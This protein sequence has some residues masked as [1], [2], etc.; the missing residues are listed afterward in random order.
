MQN[1][2]APANMHLRNGSVKDFVELLNDFL[3]DRPLRSLIASNEAV[4]Q[5]VVEILLDPPRTRVPELYLVMNGNKQKGDGRFGFPDM[6]I[7]G[8][9]GSDSAVVLELKDIH[10]SGLWNGRQGHRTKWMNPSYAEMDALA[11]EVS[12]MDEEL[13]NEMRYMYWS[14]RDKRYVSTTVG[15]MRKDALAQVKRYV[16]VIKKGRAEK[17]DDSGVRDP[18]VLVKRSRGTLF[19]F[20]LMA[21]GGRRILYQAGK[22]EKTE[23]SYSCTLV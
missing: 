11:K 12:D 4:L 2:I 20:V 18:R 22:A 13:M 9:G 19:S 21:V 16:K 8:D 7:V 10:L 6:F 15:K 5:G 17:F 14:K 23:F 1:R 3:A